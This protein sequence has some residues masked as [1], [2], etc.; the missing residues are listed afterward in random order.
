MRIRKANPDDYDASG[1]NFQEGN[2]H[3]NDPAN[4]A[5]RSAFTTLC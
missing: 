2:S 3:K 4:T 1:G 5:V